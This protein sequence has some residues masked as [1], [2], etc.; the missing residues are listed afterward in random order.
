MFSLSGACYLWDGLSIY[1]LVLLLSLG[2]S[3][4]RL[5]EAHYSRECLQS[6]TDLGSKPS[7]VSMTLKYSKCQFSHIVLHTHIFLQHPFTGKW[8]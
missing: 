1:E 6:H 4:E 2:S 5:R 7:R 3:C 8:P